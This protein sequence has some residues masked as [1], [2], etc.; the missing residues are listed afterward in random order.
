M[1]R[2]LSIDP[3]ISGTGFALWSENRELPLKVGNV[4]SRA[5][6]WQTR[7]NLLPG[8]LD[9]E[10]GAQPLLQRVYIE[11]PQRF[12]SAVG[13]AASSGEES[14]LLKLTYLIG[15]FGLFF[16]ERR[17]QTHLI[18][19]NVWKAQLSK[20]AVIHRIRKRLPDIDTMKPASHTWDAI[21]LGLYARGLFQPER[22]IR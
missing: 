18:P 21:G 15:C 22:R 7:A 14:D 20:E 11:F 16:F 10:I 19:V 12:N 8:K 9:E 13:N 5:G 2:I 3:G 17:I 6:T 1:S 4:Y